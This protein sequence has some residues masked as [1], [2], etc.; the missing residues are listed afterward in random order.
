MTRFKISLGIILILIAASV[1]SGIWINS[2]CKSL[3]EL[4]DRTEQ[5]FYDGDHEQSVKLSRQL[6]EEW[7]DFRKGASVLIST[8]K[9][10]ELDRL[11]ARISDLAEN[12]S[13]ELPAELSEI[14][15]LLD[16][17]RYTVIPSPTSVF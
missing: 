10:S 4:S 13:E 5:F 8:S 1:F 9:I 16:L 17:L 2:R 12:N 7:E 3:M 6:N 14:K 15:H 11:C